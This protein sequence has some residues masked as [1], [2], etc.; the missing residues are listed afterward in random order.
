MVSHHT[1]A[2]LWGGVVP[3]DAEVHV[4]VQD[5]AHRPRRDGIHPHVHKHERRPS[6]QGRVRLT[7][8]VSTY[9]DLARELDLVDLVV[10]GDSV[11]KAGRCT[12]GEVQ[13]AA[14]AW[15]GPGARRARHAATLVRADADSPKETRLRLLLIFAGLPEPRVNWCVRNEGGQVIYRIDLACA[16]WRVAVE[17]DGRQHAEDDR[18]WGHDLGRR[19]S[20][21]ALGWGLIV[22][23]ATDVYT[24][25]SQTVDR[26]VSALRAHGM[27]LTDPTLSPLFHRHFPGR[28]GRQTM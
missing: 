27:E 1:A 10:L 13:A 24:S 18:Q 19:E 5:R 2:R 12:V 23:R 17:Y 8:P 28:P 16:E 14:K 25:P 15:H 6:R 21:G 22:C 7:D 4:S 20:L 26:V 11:V 9:L 3:D